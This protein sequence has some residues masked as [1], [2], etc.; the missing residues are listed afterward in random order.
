MH[1]SVRAVSDH[2]GTG[3]VAFARYSSRGGR[4]AQDLATIDQAINDAGLTKDAAS[5]DINVTQDWVDNGFTYG[6]RGLATVDWYLEQTLKNVPA[7]FTPS[8]TGGSIAPVDQLMNDL[9]TVSKAVKLTPSLQSALNHSKQ[10]LTHVLGPS[11]DTNLGPG[12]TDRDPLPVYYDAQVINF[13][14]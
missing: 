8:S 11:P 9:K 6:P 12:A 13:V 5:T 14:K 10:V 4:V 7:V 2:S 3:S 1:Q